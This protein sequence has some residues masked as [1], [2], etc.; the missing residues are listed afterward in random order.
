MGVW[1]YGYIRCRCR[2]RSN[3]SGGV[4]LDLEVG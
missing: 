4:G 1:I 3:F 2:D